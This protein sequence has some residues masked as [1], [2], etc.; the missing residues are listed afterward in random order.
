MQNTELLLKKLTLEEKCALLSGA[1]TFKTR[2]MP[3]HG[4]PQI[5]LSDGPH[6]LRKQAGESDHLGLNPS[7]PATCFPTASAVANSWDAALGEEIGAA[8]GEE[9]AAQEVSVVLGPGLN[10]KRNPLCGRSFEYFSEDPYLAGKLAAGYIRGIQSKGVAACPKHF[11]VNSQETRRMASDSI[12]DERTLREIYLTG[13]EIAVKEGHPRSIMSSYNLVNGTY[14]NENKHLLMEILRGEWG[15]DGAVITDWGGSNDHALGV[16]NGSTLEMPAPGGDSVRELLAA[17]ES[18]KISESDIDA[19][20]SELLPLVFDTK[21]ALDAAP[22]E[23]DAAAHHALACRA[24]EESL[25]LLKNEG[26]LL[27]LAAGSK[28]AVIGD[29]AKNPRY[30]GAGSSMVNSTQVDVLL[31]KLIDSELNVIG[32][33]QGFD[34]HGKPDAALQKSACELAT[35]ADTVILCMGLD[36]IAESEGLDRSNL[37]L[38]KNQ[39]DLLQAVA[40][41][42]PKIVVVLYSGSVVET[43]WLDNCQ[44]LLYAALGGQAG[45]GAVADALT[46]KVNPCGKLAETWP[47]AYADVPSAADFATRRKT[48]E[49]REGLYIGYRYFTTAEKAVRFPF[50]YGMSY[51]TFA[52][53]DMAAD[54]QGVSLTVTNT[55]SV[56]GTEIVQLYV[57]KKNSELFRPAKELKGF[58]RVTLAPGEKQ[59]ITIMLDD[60]AFRFWNVKANRWEIEGGEYELLVGASVEDIRLCEK[61]SV[62]GTAA[63]HPYEDRDLD[64]YYKGNVLHVSDADFEKLLGHPI[65]NGKTKIDRNLTLGELNHARSPL[66]WLVWL[67]LTILLD[68]SYKRGKPDLNILF[69]YNMPLRALAKMTNG[70]ISMGMVDGIVMELQGFWILGLVRVIYEAIKNVVLNAQMEKRLR[71]A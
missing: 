49:Y 32:Y 23:F 17:V 6:G 50:G 63:V 54:E 1:E 25:V 10:M 67:V 13:F 44:A 37:R 15:F 12:V 2:G 34:R 42:N 39:L 22:R 68:V 48:V 16:K 58:A 35:Q 56:A 38:A 24:A 59:R 46:G 19:R 29:F 36:E 53:S 20:L 4:I 71:G 9:A 52:Y 14:A 60:K 55:G 65:P 69:Q 30:Q 11:A 70:A 57:A 51:T 47:L 43:P 64:C 7:V 26:S 41:V 18:G 27:P 45:A 3:E 40:A 62:H 33:Q 28:V 8:L 61:I 5:W 31:D 66:G 21:A